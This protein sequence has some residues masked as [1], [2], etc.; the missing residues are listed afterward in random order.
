MKTVLKAR[1]IAI[2]LYCDLI[3]IFYIFFAYENKLYY[4]PIGICAN[5]FQI[6]G[7]LK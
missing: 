7:G 5:R 4:K 2:V 3:L 1:V 6:L